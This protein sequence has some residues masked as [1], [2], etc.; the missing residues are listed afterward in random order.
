MGQAQSGIERSWTRNTIEDVMQGAPVWS[1]TF[2]NIYCLVLQGYIL[3]RRNGI[4][5]FVVKTVLQ[6]FQ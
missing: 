3:T 6:F 4:I 5:V 1:I 2:L